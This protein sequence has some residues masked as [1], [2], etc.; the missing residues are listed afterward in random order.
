MNVSPA[1]PSRHRLSAWIAALRWSCTVLLLVLLAVVLDLVGPLVL[2]PITQS[3]CPAGWWHTGLN[4]RHCSYAPIS[5]GKTVI[6]YTLHLGCAVPLTFIGAPRW[7]HRS[8]LVLLCGW[9]AW[10]VWKLLVHRYSWIQ[11]W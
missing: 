10:P 6:L 3:M 4:W 8:C 1:V 5:I 2:D 9:M 7:K 11:F